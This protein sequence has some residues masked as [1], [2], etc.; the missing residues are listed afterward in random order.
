MDGLSGVQLLAKLPALV[1]SG[2]A[3]CS[4]KFAFFEGGGGDEI[5][6]LQNYRMPCIQIKYIYIIHIYLCADF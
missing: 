6:Y 1:L 4:A 2:P 3:R 5:F